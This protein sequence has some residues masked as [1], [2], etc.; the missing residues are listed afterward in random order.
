MTSRR[1]S[2]VAVMT[3]GLLLAHGSP[4][5]AGKDRHISR[6]KKEKQKKVRVQE[7]MVRSTDGRE[8]EGEVEV[9]VETAWNAPRNQ[10]GGWAPDWLD[11]DGIDTLSGY[12]D[13]VR[14]ALDDEGLDITVE[15]FFRR[16][17]A[18]IEAQ[19]RPPHEVVSIRVEGLDFDIKNPFM[20]LFTFD[21]S[22]ENIVLFDAGLWNGGESSWVT[23]EDSVGS[24]SPELLDYRPEGM[25]LPLWDRFREA[26]GYLPGTPPAAKEGWDPFDARWAGY[27]DGDG[28]TETMDGRT[29]SGTARDG[30]TPLER[31]FSK[32]VRAENGYRRWEGAQDIYGGDET[33]RRTVNYD[34][35]LR[36][37]GSGV[38]D[39]VYYNLS[40][41]KRVQHEGEWIDRTW[42]ATSARYTG[43]ND[44][45]RG[46]DPVFEGLVW[47]PLPDTVETVPVQ[48]PEQQYFPPAI[49][50]PDPSP[51]SEPDP[52]A[53]PAD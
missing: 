38:T 12:T 51:T 3:L 16:A 50:E 49:S 18:A 53:A 44:R 43:V 7:G 22:R 34:V 20:K 33:T 45:G 23:L 4:V 30:E 10:P 11:A 41:T 39:W 27:L 48:D 1:I 52:F 35:A 42:T 29:W 36:P 28:T 19:G 25:S 8:A 2:I 31:I 9:E 14:S 17:R 15:E 46:I 6:K 5:L 32:G 40:G 26:Q 21:H 37:G 47:S 24:V 13:R